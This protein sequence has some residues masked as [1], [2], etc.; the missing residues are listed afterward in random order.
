MN[1]RIDKLDFIKVEKF[2]SAK[3][4]VKR[5]RRQAKDQGKHLQ[6]TH[7]KKDYIQNT[8]NTFNS[9]QE[10]E[11]ANRKIGKRFEHQNLTKEDK[12]MARN[13]LKKHSTSLSHSIQF[14]SVTQLC[15][16]L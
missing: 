3:D 11:Q 12:P 6:K 10:N 8:Q 15:P 1:E 4:I 2:C 14:S 5:M 9:T 13:H 16:T 7:L